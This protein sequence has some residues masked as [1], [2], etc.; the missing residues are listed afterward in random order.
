MFTQN[1]FKKRLDLVC[2]DRSTFYLLDILTWNLRASCYYCPQNSLL[3]RRCARSFLQ[4][5]EIDVVVF[6]VKSFQVL[7]ESNPSCQLCWSWYFEPPPLQAYFS[8]GQPAFHLGYDVAG[9]QSIVCY[10]KRDG[11][12]YI[13]NYCDHG[14]ADARGDLHVILVLKRYGRRTFFIEC[15]PRFLWYFK[16]D[17]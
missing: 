6:P 11:P 7:L 10:K 8:Y 3:F 9:L 4:S 17:L 14:N 5:V 16:A 2:G 13:K 12:T 15:A 1:D